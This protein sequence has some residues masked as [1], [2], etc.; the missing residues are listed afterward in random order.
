MTPVDLK[1]ALRNDAFARRKAAY[2]ARAR[3][4]LGTECA[5]WL[6]TGEGLAGTTGR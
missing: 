3:T 4:E 5:R 6:S 2:E 1:S